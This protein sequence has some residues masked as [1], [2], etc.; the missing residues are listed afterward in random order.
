MMGGDITVESEA[1]EGSTFTIRLP[2]EVPEL[3]VEPGVTSV[4]EAGVFQEEEGANTVLVIDDDDAVRDLLER[5]LGSEGFRVV[6][7]GG[8]EEGLRLA[9]ELR[10]EVIT[11]DAIMPGMDGWAVL[12]KL[13]ADP[14]VSGIPVVMLTI[15]DDKN[16]G[17]A[18]GA[19]DYLTKPVERQRL[20]AVLK[21]YR[22]DHSPC[23]VLV[24]DDEPANRATLRHMLEKEGFEVAEA[25][26]GR[27]ALEHVARSGPSAILLDL[28]MPEMD[29]FEFVAN[30]RGRE[31]WRDIPVVVL[32][33]KDIT[34]Q[35]RLRLDG[36]VTQVLQ[37]RELGSDA[38]LAEVRDLIK[39]CCVGQGARQ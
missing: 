5:F 30:L 27:V 37:K 26:N 38:L 22:Q 19:A 35:D 3:T 13:K 25:E 6:S 18:L 8:G 39:A 23:N 16:M 7:A 17:Y 36:Y 9:R 4:P 2:A 28:M 1:G 12:S 11:L 24:V 15:I 34:H 33:A 32:T 20:V 10:P 31:D 14:D 29:G 21:K